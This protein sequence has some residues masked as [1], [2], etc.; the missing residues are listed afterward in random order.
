MN[1]A[2]LAKTAAP[3]IALARATASLTT[4]VNARERGSGA[5]ALNLPVQRES[6]AE[7][8]KLSHQLEAVFVNQLFQA[9]RASIPKDPVLGNA[10]G[11][12][13]FTQIMDEKLAS[14]ASERMHRG[15]GEHLYRQ[16]ARRLPEAP[17]GKAP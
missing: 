5:I 13:M 15:L 12:E 4:N 8:R 1:N 17:E 7:V 2:A 11:A 3:N 16:L 6:R 9:M 10:P 14:Q